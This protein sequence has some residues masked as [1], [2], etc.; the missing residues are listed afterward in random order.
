MTIVI[1]PLL[2][3]F[4]VIGSPT[5]LKAG[6]SKQQ[7]KNLVTEAAKKCRT[8]SLGTGVKL[9]LQIDWFSQSRRNRPDIDNI[10]KPILDALKEVIYIDDSQVSNVSAKHHNLDTILNFFNEPMQI[11]QPLL[12]GEKEYIYI[13]VYRVH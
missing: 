9:D 13:R 8:K 2:C 4:E 5:S 6:N 3:S 11:I 10:L 12:V 1:R 7:W